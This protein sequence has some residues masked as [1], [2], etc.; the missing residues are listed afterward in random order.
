MKKAFLYVDPRGADIYYSAPG[1]VTFGPGKTGTILVWAYATA[2]APGTE[3]GNKVLRII[4]DPANETVSALHN[5]HFYGWAAYDASG[6]RTFVAAGDYN[7][8]TDSTHKWGWQLLACSWDLATGHIRVFVDDSYDSGWAQC[9]VPGT[10][11][12][13]IYLG[14]SAAAGHVLPVYIQYVAAWSGKLTAVQVAELY[15]RGPRYVPVAEDGDGTLT[16]LATFNS[17]YAADIAEGDGELYTDAAPAPDRYCRMPDG[18]FEYA[19]QTY[20]IGQP[21]HDG[22]EFDRLPV[23]AVF[24]PGYQP[25]T[26]AT[27]NQAT[28]GKIVIAADGS[29]TDLNRG[30]LLPGARTLSRGY[31]IPLTPVRLV[32]A[33]CTVR[34]RLRVDSGAAPRGERIRLGPVDY[35]HH[36]VAAA[37]VF[38]PAGYGSFQTFTVVDDPANNATSFK[39]DLDEAE[40]EYWNGAYCLFLQGTNAGRALKVAGYDATAGIVTLETSLPSVPAAGDLGVV[41][42]WAR[43]E[44]IDS[45][46]QRLNWQNLEVILD[47]THGGNDDYF[48]EVEWIY[49]ADNTYGPNYPFAYH[50]NYL[51]FDRGRTVVMEGIGHAS[52]DADAPAALYGRAVGSGDPS[53]F[54]ATVRIQKVEVSGPWQY[55]LLRA[56][57]DQGPSLADNFMVWL[58]VPAET[59]GISQARSVKVWRQRG[60]VLSKQAPS[61]YPVPSDVQADLAGAWWRAGGVVSLWPLQESGDQVIVSAVAED[62]DGVRRIGYLV[63][64]WNATAGR[65]DWVDETPPAGKSN[66]FFDGAALSVDRA[67]D[68]PTIYELAARVLP[69]PDGKWILHYR[70]K[71]SDPDHSTAGLLVGAED[72]WSFDRQRHWYRDNPLM[73]VRGAVDVP[74]L[75]GGGTGTF[76]NR[77][78]GFEV[79]YDPYTEYPSRRYLA[80]ARGK[81]IVFGYTEGCHDIRPLLMYRSSDGQVWQSV[82]GGREV[83]PA[84]AREYSVGMAFVYDDSTLAMSVPGGKLWVSEDG[85]HWQVLYTAGT[86]L[87]P[88]EIPG[89]GGSLY[90]VAS[91]R[92]ADLRVYYYKSDLG[93][94]MATI[95]YNGETYYELEADSVEGFV[96]TSA[97]LRPGETW[98]RDL[99]IN[100]DPGEGSVSVEVVD[101]QTERVIAGFGE[102]EC[103]SVADSVEQA[104]RW[105]GLP[106][107]EVTAEC[108]RLR[109]WLRRGDVAQQSPRLYGWKL[110]LRQPQ[111]PKA[112]GLQVNGQATPA[113]VTDPSPTFSWTYSDPQSLPQTAYRI[114]V[115]ST[116]ANLDAGVGDIWDSGVVDSSAQ[117]AAYGGPPLSSYTVYFWKVLVRNSEGVWSE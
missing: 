66:P 79:I 85:A 25:E 82:M 100:A 39:T 56:D 60:V 17:G 59:S 11:A 43:L 75:T 26:Y 64:T 32:Q 30:P 67:P 111:R 3:Q 36:P 42:H 24:H 88:D 54:T 2:I 62:A 29:Q 33:P 63:G 52:R 13:R 51:R 15:R 50:P 55:Q 57:G 31:E 58:T 16:F 28:E 48:P 46:G 71:M 116:Q 80:F 99:V 41:A 53:T 70:S 113:G 38:E 102:T 114:L 93:L 44:G 83:T 20:F 103:D 40:G 5:E 101:A 45:T 22:Q 112:S 65:I 117:E 73:G 94:N 91:F 86:F 49:V 9:G 84:C 1:N 109:F 61:K 78:A 68:T 106:L 74:K 19:R 110:A 104:V 7:R 81:S 4:A 107:S 69:A 21:R 37:N 12:L 14:P 8:G 97:I 76:G 18:Q 98:D 89:E 35:I 96:E 6:Q 115:A 34:L 92:L 95:R 108:I 87:A 47:E 23:W 105:L 10:D 77:D 90:A 72:R 27:D